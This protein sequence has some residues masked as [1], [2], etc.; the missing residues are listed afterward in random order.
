M[1][2]EL[3]QKLILYHIYE[4]KKG[5]KGMQIVVTLVT[6]C[7]TYTERDGIHKIK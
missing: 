4:S 5:K 6:S 7:Y 1:L 2:I 3:C